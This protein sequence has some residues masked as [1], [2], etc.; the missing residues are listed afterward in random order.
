MN[1]SSK[2]ILLA[3]EAAHEAGKSLR[4]NLYTHTAAPDVMLEVLA[5]MCTF[6]HYEPAKQFIEAAVPGDWMRIWLT[7]ANRE[8]ALFCLK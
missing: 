3:H 1:Q 6:I 5:P 4:H 8:G 7:T 2:R